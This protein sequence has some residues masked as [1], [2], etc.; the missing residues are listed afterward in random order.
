MTP[1]SILQLKAAWFNTLKVSV[2]TTVPQSSAGSDFQLGLWH[3]LRLG[4]GVVGVDVEVGR[5][6]SRP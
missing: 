2:L 3:E 6:A 5:R 4:G 1:K